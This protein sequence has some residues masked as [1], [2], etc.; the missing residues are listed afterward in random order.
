M[1]NKRQRDWVTPVR[2]NHGTIVE[3]ADMATI[4]ALYQR[5]AEV[6]VLIDKL[7]EKQRDLKAMIKAGGDSDS[8]LS[9]KLERSVAE[10]ERLE[11]D[12]G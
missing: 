5:R 3:D 7:E 12:D 8:H 1:L 9:S 10:E 2:E 11:G 6:Q 4:Q